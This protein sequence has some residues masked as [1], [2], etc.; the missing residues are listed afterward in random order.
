MADEQT[1]RS[2]AEKPSHP[3]PQADDNHT[4]KA[5]PTQTSVNAEPPAPKESV[6]PSPAKKKGPKYEYFTEF[7]R[8]A[9]SR[10]GQAIRLSKKD[11]THL[12]DGPMPDESFFST[13]LPELAQAD[14]LL[15]VPAQLFLAGIPHR[16][17]LAFWRKVERT[18]FAMLQ[19]H[20]A[21]AGL[22]DLLQNARSAGE[23]AW[24]ALD[25]VCDP[26]YIASSPSVDT[27]RP[28][29]KADTSK[30]QRNLI[31]NVVL[32]L[33]QLGPA[34]LSSVIQELYRRQ[35]SP[36]VTAV[37]RSIDRLTLLLKLTDDAAAGL[38][39]SP[40]VVE[41]EEQR[42]IA[43]YATQR[44]AETASKLADSQNMVDAQARRIEELAT[45]V[46]AL[47]SQLGEQS[48]KHQADLTH[49]ADDLERVRSRVV[50]RIEEE[51]SLLEEGLAALRRNKGHVMEDH[52]ER[53]IN[54]LRAELKSL[55][56][57]SN[58]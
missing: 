50:R 28:L 18:Y 3:E 33:T 34:D 51:V 2:R 49:A 45:R 27:G 6:A 55:S 47:E 16:H 57:G 8:H 42:R 10:K 36:A 54:G 19:Q 40:F 52:A 24:P 56:S 29:K 20:P 1:Q 30:L 32:W 44:E 37:P 17:T 21:S 46:Q 41:A 7:V 13:T 23:A 26:T 38:A 12:T 25:A 48:E 22:L 53:V 5:A 11:V 58:S 4:A 15:A 31:F 14:R 39:A 43:E 9:Y 35:W